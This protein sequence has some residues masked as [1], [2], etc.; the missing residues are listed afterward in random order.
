MA[1]ANVQGVA[2]SRP[3]SGKTLAMVKASK[4]PQPM[5]D[6]LL[7]MTKLPAEA[8]TPANRPLTKVY[9]WQ[10]D[11]ANVSAISS[12]TEATSAVIAKY[13]PL[14]AGVVFHHWA[15]LDTW[16]LLGGCFRY[17]VVIAGSVAPTAL[18]FGL[19]SNEL[20]SAPKVTASPSAKPT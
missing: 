7:E 19:G 4:G 20:C 18:T 8:D 6:A 17:R 3:I 5:V 12:I 10:F 16:A 13:P 1:G 14:R 9:L 11:S 2:W 15:P